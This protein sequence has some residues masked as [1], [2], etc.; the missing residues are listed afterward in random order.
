MF[1]LVDFHSTL[2]CLPHIKLYGRT[3][4][5]TRPAHSYSL[6][7]SVSF[8][9]LITFTDHG[10]LG[11]AGIRAHSATGALVCRTPGSSPKVFG[12]VE[13]TDL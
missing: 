12:R 3:F 8:A 9:V 10:S 2:A 1:A 4:V 5:D 13:V 6:S 7:D 11:G